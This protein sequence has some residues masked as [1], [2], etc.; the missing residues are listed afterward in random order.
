MCKGIAELKSVDSALEA[1]RKG[2]FDFS[3]EQQGDKPIPVRL[4][5]HA[6]EIEVREGA[7]SGPAITKAIEVLQ[8]LPPMKL[9]ISEDFA[10]RGRGNVRLRD[11]GAKAGVKLYTIVATEP[12][13]V[14]H[15]AVDEEVEEVGAEEE[16][17]A[18]AEAA[19]ATASKK[20]RQ[21]MLIAAAVVVLGGGV[22]AAVLLMSKPKAAPAPTYAASVLKPTPTGPQPA[23]GRP[24]ESIP[25]SI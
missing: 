20:K 1:G 22:G 18:V 8:T 25:M 14:Q 7:V 3:P 10:K 16:E 11:S 21:M 2:E 6:G 4:L 17:A 23:T 24:L 13:P 9:F 15:A 5:L 19:A 12:Q